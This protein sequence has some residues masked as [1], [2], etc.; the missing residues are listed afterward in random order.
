MSQDHQCFKFCGKKPTVIK[1]GHLV[2]NSLFNKLAGDDQNFH[3]M[4]EKLQNLPKDVFDFKPNSVIKFVEC[5]RSID[6]KSI[7]LLRK[8]LS[9][10][11]RNYE[12]EIFEKNRLPGLHYHATMK[13]HDGSRIIKIDT[14]D[15]NNQQ[16]QQ[17]QQKIIPKTSPR[18]SLESNLVNK[19][20]IDPPNQAYISSNQSTDQILLCGNRVWKELISNDR[21]A[22]QKILT[23]QMSHLYDKKV[24]KLN[25]YNS[26]DLACS[27]LRAFYLSGAC[28]G[29]G[30]GNV[31][32]LFDRTD[33]KL[34]FSEPTMFLE[35]NS[36]K[37]LIEEAF[38]NCINSKL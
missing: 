8:S 26:R 28:S 1:N 10:L 4:S 36:R 7:E 6:Y 12:Q 32:C 17:Q 24:K 11:S 31:R 2:I 33:R 23:H 27:E 9:M 15:N 38:E 21:I 37:N 20:K 30:S 22:L 35:R 13:L 5:E 16:Q 29:S 34:K 14:T 18:I 19:I 3:I 25:F